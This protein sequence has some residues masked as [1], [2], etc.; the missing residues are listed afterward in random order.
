MTELNPQP[1]LDHEEGEKVWKRNEAALLLYLVLNEQYFKFHFDK[2]IDFD[3]WDR[4]VK[5]FKAVAHEKEV[6]GSHGN[7]DW[8]KLRL[9]HGDIFIPIRNIWKV[10]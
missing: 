6:P 8:E 4:V 1:G 9:H 3:K 7:T 5:T 2:F 10:T